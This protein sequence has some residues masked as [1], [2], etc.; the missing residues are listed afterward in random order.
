MHE[1]IRH[2]GLPQR[3]SEDPRIMLKEQQW[4][5][6]EGRKRKKK[7]KGQPKDRNKFLKFRIEKGK[8]SPRKRMINHTRYKY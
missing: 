5:F 4:N 8:M 7:K 3:E 2:L 1:M 6:T